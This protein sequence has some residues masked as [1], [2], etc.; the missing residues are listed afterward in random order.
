MPTVTNENIRSIARHVLHAAGASE[1]Q[2]DVVGTHLANANLAG[3]DSH[4][5]I[6]ISQYV[7]N[8]R[9]GSIDPKGKPEVTRDEGAIAQVNGNATFGQVVATMAT[10]L[11]MDKAR[12]YGI[13]LVG[14]YNLGHTGRVGTYPERVANEGMA[15]MMWT[16][17]VG[18][19]AANSVAPFGGSERRLGTNPVSMSF[20]SP[21]EGPILLDFATSVAAEGKLRVYR[22]RGHT[23][24]SEWVLTKDG[25]PSRDPNDYYSG[26]ALLP[27]GGLDGGHKGYG[28]SI[29]VTL[30]GAVLGSLG[31]QNTSMD[32]QKSGSSIVVIDLARMA[33]IDHI[34]ELVGNIVEYVKDTPPM[35]GSRGVLYPGEIEAMTRKQRL[36]DGVEI[37]QSTWDEVGALIKEFGLEAKIGPLPV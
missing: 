9:E 5:F 13:G 15:A 26:G 34:R 3:H 29:M 33:P 4:G 32:S 27:M 12:Q 21:T 28:L 36:A 20:P 7:S 24:P 35:E 10:E 37:E 25:V 22:A 19:T 11:A 8:I 6:R 17:F 23:L 30:F 1:E 31:H 16:G 2:A 18:G 14:M